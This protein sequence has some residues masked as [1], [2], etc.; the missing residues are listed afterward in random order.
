MNN[1]AE[2]S[3]SKFDVQHSKYEFLLIVFMAVIAFVIYAKTLTGDFIFDDV[4]NIKDNPHLRLTHITAE[5]LLDAAFEGPSPRRP[6]AK[7]SFALNYYFHGYNVTS[8]HMVNIL[9]HIANGV[10]LYLL[11]V[12]TWRTPTDSYRSKASC[13]CAS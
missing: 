13:I 8:F 1:M 4:P 7:L 10:L 12:F 3:E 5:N 2:Y 6:V 9:I 11:I